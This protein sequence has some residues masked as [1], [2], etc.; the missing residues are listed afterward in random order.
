MKR[1]ILQE[2]Q[3]E[4]FVERGFIILR[5]A[6]PRGVAS[7]WVDEGYRRIGYDRH[8]PSTWQEKERLH[9]PLSRQVDLA[10]FAPRP[11]QAVCDLLGGEE[12]IAKPYEWSDGF[13]FNFGVGADRPWEAPSPQSPGWHKDGDFF[14]HFLDSPEQGLL[15]IVCWT[16]IRHE[17]GGT[18]IAPD[19]VG[20]VA[21]FL[22]DHPEGVSPGDPLWKGLIGQCTEFI[23]LTGN[24]GDVVLHH[25]FML[26]AHSQNVLRVER[27]I[28]NPP[29]HL[30]EPMD[31]DRSDE[32]EFSAV[33][34][35]VLRG[36]GKKRHAF[37]PTGPREKIVPE[38]IRRQQELFE[39]AQ[40]ASGAS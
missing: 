9:L 22:A 5:D 32:R 16:D 15:T 19:S 33:E 23:E 8:D 7:Q 3:I 40:Q 36:L 11:W 4:E 39:K 26:H 18:F 1:Q 29:V 30:K 2:A 35:G 38:R 24:A 13:I 28:T 37:S 12:R 6:F 34:R 21:R 14:R 25:P 17:G 20:V 10:T 27:V 31:F